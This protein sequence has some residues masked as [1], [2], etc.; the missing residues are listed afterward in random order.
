MI[1]EVFD[2]KSIYIY[3]YMECYIKYIWN[4][5]IHIYGMFFIII[6]FVILYTIYKIH[7]YIAFSLY[8]NFFVKISIKTIY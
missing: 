7:F 3:I 5:Y 8:T 2:N 6:Q 1:I 4:I